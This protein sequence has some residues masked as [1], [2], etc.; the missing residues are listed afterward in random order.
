MVIVLN[1]KTYLFSKLKELFNL[2]TKF[3]LKLQIF[4]FFN[5]PQSIYN[6]RLMFLTKF[7]N[8]IG[9]NRDIFYSFLNL[10]LI[11]GI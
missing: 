11:L 3:L 5:A 8:E 6:I 7:I 9:I 10:L 4:Y 1:N 2:K